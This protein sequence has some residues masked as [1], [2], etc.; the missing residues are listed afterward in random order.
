MTAAL[1]P[2]TEYLT[3]LAIG[4]L[5]IYFNSTKDV[6]LA[7]NLGIKPRNGPMLLLHD[8]GKYPDDS[9]LT[10]LFIPDTVFVCF[11]IVFNMDD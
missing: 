6:T 7:T 11:R 10:K 3:A 2:F 8:L 9:R 5:D 1:K 4:Q